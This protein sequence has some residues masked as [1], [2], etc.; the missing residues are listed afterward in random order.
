MENESGLV[1]EPLTDESIELMRRRI[2]YPNPTLRGSLIL[3]PWN[4]VASDDSIRRWAI[5]NGDDNPLYIDPAYAASTRWGGVVAPPGFEMSMGAD[6]SPSMEPQFA[7]ATRKALR[8]IHLFNSGVEAYYHQPVRPGDELFRSAWVASVKD[9]ASAFATRSV[10]V[11]NAQ[12][13]WNQRE[14]AVNSGSNWFI[15]AERRKASRTE[16]KYA[17]DSPACYTDEQLRE[18]EDAYDQQYLRGADPL[19]IEDCKVGQA[20]PLMVKGPLTITD[21]I[22]FH[23]GAGWSPYGNWPHRLAYESRKH[24]RGFYT[25]NE[26]NAWDTLQRIHWEPQLAQQIGVQSS[27]DIGPMRF[28]MLAHYLTNFAG[29]DGWVYYMRT[30]YRTFN[31]MGD[32]TWLSG[33]ITGVR[34]DEVLGPMIEI[35]A[36]GI[37]QRGVEN[38]RGKGILLVASRSRGP[39]QLPPPPPLTRHRRAS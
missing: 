18:I 36:R 22:N 35:D 6:R 8:G 7:E 14:E 30:E 9:K 31:Y 21:L 27:Y 10:L 37:N 3:G 33:Q 11:T 4:R 19:Y 5:C 39:A 23:M 26:F 24:S 15:H 1:V 16:G 28:A 25:R 20:L 12:Q 38:L 2:G 13:T 29:D 17:K 32:T 34:T